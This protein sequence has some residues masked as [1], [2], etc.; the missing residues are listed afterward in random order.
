M[1]LDIEYYT[2][3]VFFGFWKLV[4]SHGSNILDVL[5]FIALNDIIGLIFWVRTRRMVYYVL[6][7]GL[8]GFWE[9][10]DWRIWNEHW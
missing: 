5:D 3:I 7:A 10:L 6:V 9:F 4:S 1:M 8:F 2:L